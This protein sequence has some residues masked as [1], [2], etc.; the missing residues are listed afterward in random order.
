MEEKLLEKTKETI[1]LR[2]RLGRLEKRERKLG[3]VNMEGR[4]V[5]KISRKRS[6][7][8]ILPNNQRRLMCRIV[9]HFFHQDEVST[10]INGKSGEI[11]K[12]GQ[13]FRKRALTDNMANLHRRFQSENPRHKLS[14]SQFCKLKPFWIVHR[15]IKD[16]ETCACKTH[17]NFGLKIKKLHQLG[18]VDVQD[19]QQLQE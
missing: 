1:N 2:K 9:S 12:N 14:M 7:Q 4:E 10:V 16:R 15:R 18:I 17:E 8:R 3:L 13:I 11:R 6:H 19:M 5:Q